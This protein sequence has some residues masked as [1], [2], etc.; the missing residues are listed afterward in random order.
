M[1]DAEIYT[2][3]FDAFSDLLKEYE[4]QTDTKNVLKVLETGA[5]EFVEDVRN[6]PRPRSRMTAP[7]YTHLL[8]EVTYQV[9]K[10]EVLTGW[11]KY[12]GPMVETERSKWTEWHT[13]RQRSGKTRKDTIKIC[14]KKYLV[15]EMIIWQ[16]KINAR[17]VKRL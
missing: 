7:G 10:D 13:W 15:K 5:K 6:L 9:A 4:K 12:Y 8:D 14:R 16:L 1:S 17:H 2:D 11:G 3:G